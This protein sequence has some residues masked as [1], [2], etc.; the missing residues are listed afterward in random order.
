MP[1]LAVSEAAILQELDKLVL[2]PRL[3]PVLDATAT[4]LEHQLSAE[5]SRL[6]VWEPLGLSLYG[7]PVPPSI[8]SSW[9][10]VLRANT[11]SGAERH[12]NSIQ[13]VMSWRGAGDL[14]TE[15]RGQWI[16]HPLVS[17]PNEAL[18]RRWL[19]IPAGVWHQGVMGGENWVVVSFHT[20][21]AS[22]LIEERPGPEG[23]GS[24]KRFYVS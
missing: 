19:S 12:P 5:P 13:R 17:R 10:F 7:M 1:D 15:Q 23:R 16:S 2:Q 20:V 14:Q 11:V 9:M 18:E 21:V 6:L 24:T 4:R 8:R 3:V 22:E